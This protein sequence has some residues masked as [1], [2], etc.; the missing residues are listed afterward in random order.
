MAGILGLRL[1]E[2]VAKALNFP[3]EDVDSGP[4][5]QMYYGG[6]RVKAVNLNHSLV[7]VWARYTTRQI[8]VN[9]DTCQRSLIRQI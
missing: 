3:L 7:I 4:T 5:V 1:T 8:Q 9:G 2:S 6:L